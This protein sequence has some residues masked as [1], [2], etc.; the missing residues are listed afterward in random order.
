[1]TNRSVVEEQWTRLILLGC[2]QNLQC[3]PPIK[4]LDR[5]ETKTKAMVNK[6]ITVD[7]R[8]WDR[9][10]LPLTILTLVVCLVNCW[11]AWNLLFLPPALLPVFLWLNLRY[12]TPKQGTCTRTIEGDRNTPLLLMWL[13]FCLVVG[14]T[15]F[16]LDH[17]ILWHATNAP[18]KPYHWC[19]FI[20][21]IVVMTSVGSVIE[22]RRKSAISEVG[23]AP[24]DT[25]NSIDKMP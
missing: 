2:V 11:L 17:Y 23:T 5:S 3:E 18:A 22:G 16:A 15:L 10:M 9:L 25:H 13:V 19:V 8:R 12:S 1:M 24:N 6:F 4:V 20:A 14:I 7:R 21:L